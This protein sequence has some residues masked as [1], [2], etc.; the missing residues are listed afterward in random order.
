MVLGASHTMGHHTDHFDF[1]EEVLRCGVRLFGAITIRLLAGALTPG[2]AGRGARG[3]S[4]ALD[5]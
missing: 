2:L 5:A 1:D 4:G 3:M